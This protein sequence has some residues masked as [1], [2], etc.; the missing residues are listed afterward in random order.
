M[1]SHVKAHTLKLEETNTTRILIFLIL[2]SHFGNLKDRFQFKKKGGLFYFVLSCWF[3]FSVAIL[4]R[5]PS[6]SSGSSLDEGDFLFV[7][8]FFFGDELTRENIVCRESHKC[9]H[10]ESMCFSEHRRMMRGV[11]FFVFL[12]ELWMLSPVCSR[13][14]VM[15]DMEV[16]F[17]HVESAVNQ[18]DAVSE[19][20]VDII[21]IDKCVPW[22]VNRCKKNDIFEEWIDHISKGEQGMD[23]VAVGAE[24][25]II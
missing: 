4:E 6:A 13:V 17:E 24:Q 9:E 7:C 16:F 25:K 14:L 8:H 10:I 3:R 2:L 12:V 5:T 11:F 22:P 15:D 23:G 21:R 20:V 1:Y 18:S 19:F